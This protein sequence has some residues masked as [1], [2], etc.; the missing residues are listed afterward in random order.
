MHTDMQYEICAH[1]Q[2]NKVFVYVET[3]IA[4]WYVADTLS[5]LHTMQMQTPTWGTVSATCS[6]ADEIV[7]HL[8]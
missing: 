3:F 5:E 6:R 2:G 1:T 4:A 7:E 8:S